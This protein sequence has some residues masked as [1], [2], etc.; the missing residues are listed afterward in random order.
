MNNAISF[1]SK[2]RFVDKNTF[3]NTASG[4]EIEPENRPAAFAERYYIPTVRTCTGGGILSPNNEAYGF[5]IYD[6]ENTNKTV[7]NRLKLDILLFDETP[8]RALIIGSKKH[9]SRPYSQKNFSIIKNCLEKHIKNVTLFEEHTDNFAQ[10]SLHYDLKTDTYTILT[11]FF[12][13]GK[14]E[15]VKTLADLLGIFKNI[16]I[17]NGDELFIGKQQ[18]LKEFCPK[19]FRK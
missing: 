2:I 8:E 13:D 3:V 14:E 17:A 4:K 6:G 16:K 18:I 12:K 15:C 10:S 11:Q 1:K 5:H 9:P 19:I 7:A